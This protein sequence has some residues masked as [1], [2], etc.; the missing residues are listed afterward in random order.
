MHSKAYKSRKV[1][2]T[3]NLDGGNSFQTTLIN[4]AFSKHKRIAHQNG[5]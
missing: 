2:M 4:L 1:K 5:K 3:K